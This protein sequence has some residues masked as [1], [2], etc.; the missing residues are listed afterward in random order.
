MDVALW[1][2]FVGRM[3]LVTPCGVRQRATYDANDILTKRKNVFCVPQIEKKWKK[4][5]LFLKIIVHGPQYTEL[6]HIHAPF[7]VCKQQS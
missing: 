4:K 7:M 5:L 1:Y 3:N 2:D 6:T